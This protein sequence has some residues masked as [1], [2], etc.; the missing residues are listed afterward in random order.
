MPIRIVISNIFVV[1]VFFMVYGS[2]N[3]VSSINTQRR[4]NL[5]IV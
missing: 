1:G 2:D 4:Q 5:C 3:S